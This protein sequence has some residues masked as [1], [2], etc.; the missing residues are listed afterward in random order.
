MAKAKKGAE[1]QDLDA[2]KVSLNP[3][4]R[5]F[6]IEYIKDHN[7]TQAAI[8]AG[9]SEKTATE[10]AARLLTNVKV[11]EFIAELEKDA[12]PNAEEIKRSNVKFWKDARDDVEQR[13]G[14]RLKASELLGDSIGQF[15]K[16]LDVSLYDPFDIYNLTH[17]E[18]LARIAELEARK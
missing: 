3:K 6:C 10:Q 5:T 15:I 11:Q 13:M 17:E 18:I 4:Q 8:R 16:K 2:S 7:A 9:Y 14:D 1:T 12:I